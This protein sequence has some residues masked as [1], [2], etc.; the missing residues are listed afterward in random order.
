MINGVGGTN[1]YHKAYITEVVHVLTHLCLHRP[2]SAGLGAIMVP[3]LYSVTTEGFYLSMPAVCYLTQWFKMM[4]TDRT[5]RS[6]TA[7]LYLLARS[8]LTLKIRSARDLYCTL[9]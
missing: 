9:L 3:I 2:M 6:G 8:S 1:D 7:S 5:N 4:T